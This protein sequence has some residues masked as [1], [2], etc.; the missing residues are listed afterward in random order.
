M[1]PL[2]GGRQSAQTVKTLEEYWRDKHYL[3]IN[4]MSMVSRP[5]LAKLS[6]IISRARTG[7]NDNSSV[8]PFG[9][10]N[11]ILVGDFHQ[12]PLVATKASAPLFWPCNVERDTDELL[13]HRIYEQFDVMVRLKTQV[14]VTDPGWL[15]L[16]QHV[17]NGSCSEH[18]INMLRGLVLDNATCPPTD[19]CSS[20]W[21]DAVLVTPHHAVHMQWNSMTAYEQANMENISLISC[22][23]QDSVGGRALTL[24]E[25]FAVAANPKSGHGHNR[26]ERGGLSDEVVLAIGMCVMV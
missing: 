26:Q 16:L 22:P 1:I 11:V 17:W 18:H 19:F 12:F 4:E 5:F 21:K 9:G 7:A 13:G 8:L 23:A 2:N 10:L 24:P 15:D 20:P 25:K 3:I 6:N 14:R